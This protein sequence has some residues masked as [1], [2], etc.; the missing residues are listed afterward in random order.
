MQL[1]G[2]SNIR[3]L[4][5][6]TIPRGV[7]WTVSDFVDQVSL[8]QHRYDRFNDAVSV[9]SKSVAATTI[10]VYYEN[11]QENLDAT[12]KVFN[13]TRNCVNSCSHCLP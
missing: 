10:V 2:S 4:S 1:C 7:N 12:L 5:S 9:I 11:L 8:W 3:A 13:I 6:C